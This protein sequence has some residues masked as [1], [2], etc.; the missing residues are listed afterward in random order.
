MKVIRGYFIT[1]I[2]RSV[3]IALA[4]LVSLFVFFEFVPQL[5]SLWHDDY[6]LQHILNLIAVGLPVNIYELMP[7][8]VLIGTIYALSQFAANSELI[9]MRVSGMSNFKI[10]QILAQMGLIFSIFIILIG[11]IFIPQTVK[12]SEKLNFR[13]RNAALLQHFH[14]GF[15]VQDI[16]QTHKLYDDKIN[17]RFLNVQHVLR[18]RWI[19]GV[20]IYELSYKFHLTSIIF[21]LSGYYLGNNQWQLYNVQNITFANTALEAAS[22]VSVLFK[23]TQVFYSN[24]TPKIL[25]I[26]FINPDH[27]SFIELHAYIQY[28]K[29]ENQ[30]IQHYRI[31]FWKKVMYPLSVF[32]M[33]ALAFP[34]AYLH[35]RTGGI[36]FKVFT[37]IVIG[38]CFQLINNFFLYVGLLNEWPALITVILPSSLFILI[39]VITLNWIKNN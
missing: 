19:Q 35:F 5:E 13:A 14:S 18:N 30:R 8:A 31:A 28:S 10:I 12:W 37:G 21:A 15:W 20:K 6:H 24:I 4:A 11:E 36:G 2:L 39:A 25:S 17:T 34:F 16:I 33:L 1:E 9:V 26:L 3:L 32:V 38:I 7:F 22:K 27:M 29:G 23:K